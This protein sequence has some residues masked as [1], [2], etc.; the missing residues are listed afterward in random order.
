M[1]AVRVENSTFLALKCC[2]G[3][4]IFNADA[5][6][7]LLPLL[8]K[9]RRKKFTRSATR[10]ARPCIRELYAGYPLNYVQHSGHRT[11]RVA[12]LASVP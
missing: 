11:T 7:M 5:G 6:T 8:N 9:S 10:S 3:K 12:E 4:H 1:V 2:S